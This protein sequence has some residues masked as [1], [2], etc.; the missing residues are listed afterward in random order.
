MV[1]VLARRFVGA[2]PNNI[3]EAHTLAGFVTSQGWRKVALL[4]TTDSYAASGAAATAQYLQ[5]LGVAVLVSVSFTQNQQDLSFEMGRIA[6]SN[7]RIIIWVRT[8]RG[9]K[10]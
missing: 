6:A 10:R 8:E 7:A 3:A 5:E 1:G 2:Y 9:H 4:F